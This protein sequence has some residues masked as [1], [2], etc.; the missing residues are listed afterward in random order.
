MNMA[1]PWQWGYVPLP[2]TQLW[3]S[4]EQVFPKTLHLPPQTWGSSSFA[5]Q[6]NTLTCH[7][8]KRSSLHRQWLCEGDGYQIFLIG[9]PKLGPQHQCKAGPVPSL[10]LELS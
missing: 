10:H 9:F 1:E 4:L 8:A 5:R 2:G 7:P 3:G 6:G